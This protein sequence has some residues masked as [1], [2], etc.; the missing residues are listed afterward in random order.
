MSENPE[1]ATFKTLF[2]TPFFVARAPDHE[3]INKALL[4]EI[5]VIRAS[6]PNGRPDSWSCNVYTTISNNY[7]LHEQPG[8]RRVSQCILD[9]AGQFA[10]GMRYPMQKNEMSIDLCWLNVYGR[11]QWQERHNHSTY[12]IVAVY[13]VAAP[14]NCSSLILHSEQADTMIRPRYRGNDQFGKYSVQVDPEPGMIVVFNGFLRHSVTSGAV[15]GERI[16]IAA[17][18]NVNAIAEANAGVV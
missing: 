8:F 9:A 18:I 10:A 1:D 15:D 4:S 17:N 14:P 7:A 2:P 16:S 11:D 3:A 12:P 5:D 13:Y 6:T